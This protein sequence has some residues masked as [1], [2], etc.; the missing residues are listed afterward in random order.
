[1]DQYSVS[2][3]RKILGELIHRVR[4]QKTT[5]ALGHGTRKEALLIPLDADDEAPLTEVNAASESF[6]FLE[7]EPDLYTRDDLKKH[8]V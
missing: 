4:F 7:E 8:Y 6:A 2:E 5:I 1:M 3:A